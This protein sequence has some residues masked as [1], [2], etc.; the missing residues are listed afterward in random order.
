M[1]LESIV[2]VF[3]FISNLLETYISAKR[4]VVNEHMADYIDRLLFC[5]TK[6]LGDHCGGGKL[7][8]EDAESKQVKAGVSLKDPDNTY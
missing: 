4:P 5:E 1:A 7:H 6:K 3:L 8:K 2:G